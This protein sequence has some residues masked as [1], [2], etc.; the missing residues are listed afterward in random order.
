MFVTTD[1]YASYNNAPPSSWLN[2]MIAMVPEYSTDDFFDYKA[3]C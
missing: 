3:G 2:S 1:S